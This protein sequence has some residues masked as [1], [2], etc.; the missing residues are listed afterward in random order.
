MAATR[1]S[2]SQKQELV[3]RF[4]G[5]AS[6]QQLATLFGCSPTTVS[7]TAKAA[8]DL[9]DYELLLKQLKAQRG[10]SSR[11]DGGLMAELPLEIETDQEDGARPEA[12]PAS[13]GPGG[14]GDAS[15][16][17]EASDIG[18][19]TDIGEATD[20][21]EAVGAAAALT[22]SEPGE[23]PELATTG[24]SHGLEE[25]AEAVAQP[26]V[27]TE[28]S[29]PILGRRRRSGAATPSTP[30]TPLPDAD[31]AAPNLSGQVGLQQVGL[32]QVGLQAEL[33]PAADPAPAAAGPGELAI[34]DADDF[35]ADDAEDGEDDLSDDPGEE[36]CF[37]QGE[38]FVAIPVGPIIDD[39][40]IHEAVPF[41]AAV[42][43]SS[44]FLLVDKTVELQARPLRELPELGRL[45]A[46]ELDRQ[47]LVV[48]VNPRQAKRQCGRTQ[49][50]I[51]LPDPSLLERTAPYLMAQGITRLVI[52]GALYALPGA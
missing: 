52:E 11:G 10:G 15:D 20:V 31:Q 22:P 35:G 38:T 12:I 40:A 24:S 25:P 17:V 1:L 43:P 16:I 9:A 51:P 6:L 27:V 26:A 29:R 46:D 2:D 23:P 47:A 50:V 3:A 21:G 41:S 13:E 34:D 37:A 36:I 28:V 45:A 5:G 8:I 42:L 33:D 32:Q 49:R 48:F 39:L 4:C 19:P 7:R 30:A 44:A 18:A 14:Y